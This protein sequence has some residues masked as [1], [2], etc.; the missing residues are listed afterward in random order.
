MGNLGRALLPLLRPFS[1]RLRVYDPWIP[2][3]ALTDLDVEPVGLDELLATSTFVFVLATSTTENTHLLDARRLAM[4]PAGARLVLVSRAA[5]VDLDALCDR[6]ASGDLLAAIDVWPEEPAPADHPARQ[7]EG[8]V[9][10]AHRAGGIPSAFPLIGEMVV[11]DLRQV[12][13]G[14]PPMRMQ[15]ALPELVA[16]YRNKPVAR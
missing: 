9:L 2:Q 16:R 1:P 3:R 11:D 6:V 14:L 5:A 12:Q 15:L 7:L 4:L 13:A 10:S 8:V